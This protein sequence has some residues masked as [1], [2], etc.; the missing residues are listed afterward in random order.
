MEHPWFYLLWVA[1]AYLLGTVSVGDLV[2]RAKGVDIRS[3]GTGNPG[4]ANIYREIGPAFGVSVFLLD[5]GKGTAATLPLFL[6]G[7]H[8]WVAALGMAAVLAGHIF[9]LPW[10]SVG[11]T[12]MAV[13]MGTTAGLLPAGALIAVGPSLLA[14]TLSRNAGYTGAVF[15]AVSIVAGWLVD[16]DWTAALAVVLGAG[17]VLLKS[18]VQYRGR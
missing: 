11:G 17:A 18:I 14:I 3:L 13:V 1:G 16:R 9:P 6:L 15:F 12:G 7:L 5:V 4:A 10:R 8:S 2:A